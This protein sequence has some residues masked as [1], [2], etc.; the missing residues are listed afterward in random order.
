MSVKINY[1]KFYITINNHDMNTRIN[2]LKH[3]LRLLVVCTVWIIV[4]CNCSTA[5]TNK[6]YEDKTLLVNPFVGTDAHGHTYPG[7]VACFGMIQLSPDTRLN[8]WDGCSGYHYSDS[9]I[10][11][12]SHTH[13]SGTGCEDLCDVLF[14]PT[15]YGDNA[16]DYT[17]KFSHNE[18]KA[19]AGY[20]SVKM[21]NKYIIFAELTATQRNGFHKYVYDSNADTMAVVV[22]MLHR[23]R[24]LDWTV[25]LEDKYTIT[26]YRCSKSWSEKQYIY[27]AAKFNK[28]IIHSSLDTQRGLL[29]LYFGKPRE[30]NNDLDVQVS[31]SS[32]DKQ[33][34]LKNLS[35]ETLTFY[36]AKERTKQSWQ[37]ALSKIDVEGGTLA[38]QRTFYTSLYHCMICPNLYSDVDH[39]YRGMITSKI[40]NFIPENPIVKAEGYNRYTNF[41]LWDTYRSLNSLLTIIEPTRCKD[42][43]HTFL[44]YYLQSGSLP[45]WELWSWETYCMI[46]FH[47]I[48][49][50]AE[51]LQKGIS[52]GQDS[53]ILQAM[54]DCSKTDRQ[55]M[56]FFNNYGYISSEMEHESVSKTVEIAYNMYCIALLAKKLN[57]MDVYKEYIQKAQYYKNLFNPENT[58]I[59]P[60][61]NG[62]FLSPFDPKQVDINYTE[63]NG[64]QYTFYVPQD[65]NTLID[66]IGGKQAF[67][68]KLD[69]CF[70]SLDT[71]TGRNQADVTGLIGQYAHGNEPSQHMAYLYNYVGQAYKTQQLVRRILNTL[72]SDKP[73]GVCG[74]DDCG[75]MASWFV[76]SAIGFYPVCPVS[77]QYVIGSPLF[78]K[79]NIHLENGKVFT[80]LSTQGHNTPYVSK[81]KLNGKNYTKTYISHNDIMQGG[82]LE[83]TMS[84]K[85]NMAFGSKP[86]DCP[87][88]QIKDKIIVPTNYLKY[89]GTGSFEDSIK[90][91]IIT[92][93]ENLKIKDSSYTYIYNTQELTINNEQNYYKHNTALINKQ[94]L[95]AKFYKIDKGLKLSLLTNYN[96]QYTGGGDDALIDQKLGS[97]NWRLGC[98]QG[99]WGEDV[100]AIIEF[101]KPRDV[102]SIG[103]HFI[104]DEKSWIFM[105]TQVIYYTSD[106]AINWKVLDSINNPIDEHLSGCIT[107]TFFSSKPA[108]CRYIKM[109][110]KNRKTNPL[111]HISA[112]EKSWLFIDEIIIK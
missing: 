43:E 74:N 93:D 59:Q 53:L 97:D 111:W 60:K 17:M 14:T 23:D 64:W 12:F 10:Y 5:Q 62:R 61:E 18:E 11:G 65:I 82:V 48:S 100:V 45:M 34:A 32:V 110:A 106:D 56:N 4:A 19:S 36:Q 29:Y 79:A 26:G 88:E 80:I 28:P 47:G 22:N 85:P 52:I 2:N 105:P 6:R 21:Y 76:M 20:Y 91:G 46:G 55:G 1:M 16:T 73:D 77:G 57:R 94:P 81:L 33:G 90:V 50:M 75:Q 98:W 108:K 25:Q 102:D 7:A 112:G 78:D 13:L 24:T 3:L 40:E 38:E 37:K 69:E 92:L 68:N 15:C 95:K 9:I 27:F 104:Q 41:S 101:S 72:Y 66:M 42:F 70:N 49:V 107:H 54:I 58:F 109:I 30:N 71:L 96:T 86:K 63:G 99:Y 8:G 89:E 87:K 67:A 31:I 35:S 44:D 51:W 84:D 103:G 83:F 39:K